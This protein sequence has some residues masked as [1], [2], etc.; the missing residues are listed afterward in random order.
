M[1]GGKVERG[2]MGGIVITREYA[3]RCRV[4]AYGHPDQA[5]DIVTAILEMP[6]GEKH[7]FRYRAKETGSIHLPDLENELVIEEALVPPG[8]H[9]LDAASRRGAV[10]VGKHLNATGSTRHVI[11]GKP[12]EFD[13]Q[14]PSGDPKGLVHIQRGVNARSQTGMHRVGIAPSR[15]N[16]IRL[17]NHESAETDPHSSF[18]PSPFP[19]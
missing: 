5:A 3:E 2:P 13:T 7:G 4:E 11:P 15:G 10:H 16:P 1:G 17:E 18:R 9:H 19:N 8:L 14:R 6:F 12:E